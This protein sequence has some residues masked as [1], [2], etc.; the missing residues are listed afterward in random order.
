MIKRFCA[1]EDPFAEEKKQKYEQT[2]KAL[3]RVVYRKCKKKVKISVTVA[4]YGA[5]D[6]L[7]GKLETKEGQGKIFRLARKNETKHK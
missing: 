4:K 2:R 1:A 3:D 6:Q 5:Y 7:Y